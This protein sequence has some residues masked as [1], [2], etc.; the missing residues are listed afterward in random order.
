MSRV[1]LLAAGLALLLLAAPAAALAQERYVVTLAEADAGAATDRLEREGGFRAAHRYDRALDGFA[2]ALSPAQVARLRAHP[3]VRAVVPDT[4]IRTTGL[5]S[6]APRELVPPGV[7]RV[8]TATATQA[9]TA[10]DPAVAV[11]DTGID[12][13]SADLAARPGV[14]CVRPRRSPTDDNGHGTHVAG[15]IAARNSGAGVVGV[16]PGTPVYAVKVLDAKGTGLLSRF[17]CGI[18]WVTRN[19][20]ALNIRVANMSVGGPGADD[21]ACGARNGDAWHAAICRSTSAG[22]TWVASAGNAGTDLARTIPA[23]YPEVLAV[24]AMTDTDGL[25]GALG[26]RPSCSKVE[27]DDTAA[28]YSNYATSP[29]AAAHLVAAPG[30]CVTSVKRRGGTAVMSGTS[31]AAP[32][33]AGA[34]ALC[35]GSA[36]V[37]GPC[38][39]KAPADVIAQ[40]RADASAAASAFGFAGD[41]LRPA[42]GRHLGPLVSAAS[43]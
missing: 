32:H 35:L 40:V 39:G 25:P 15:T 13:A 42:A 22:V 2:A 37:P 10:A 28:T 20:A 36:G 11:L 17:L 31:M 21:G 5:V 33:A 18:D 4:P 6:L 14:N 24:T 23:A 38:A 1:A 19:A 30:T 7:R 27:R 3:R 8:R 16:A 12:L 29:T 43:Y 26:R 41:P 9:H 34:V